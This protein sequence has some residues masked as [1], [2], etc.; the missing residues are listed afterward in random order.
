MF[1]HQVQLPCG[2]GYKRV[3]FRISP[4]QSAS[5]VAMVV[6]PTVGWGRGG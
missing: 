5:V 3:S 4:L 6:L 2:S 1:L